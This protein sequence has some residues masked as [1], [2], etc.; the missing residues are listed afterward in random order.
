MDAP[1]VRVSAISAATQASIAASG[2]SWAG[3]AD[4]MLSAASA[5]ARRRTGLG[6]GGA[7]SSGIGAKGRLAGAPDGGAAGA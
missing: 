1:G 6:K 4:R 7:G 5:A 3:T 2:S